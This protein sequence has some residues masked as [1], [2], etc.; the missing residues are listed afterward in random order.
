MTETECNVTW[1]ET[2]TN[3]STLFLTVFQLIDL[4]TKNSELE[5]L[6]L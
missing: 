2:V 5:E 3:S 6:L 1:H 4:G